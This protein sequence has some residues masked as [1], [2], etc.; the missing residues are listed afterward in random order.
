MR[1]V[2]KDEFKRIYFAHLGRGYTEEYWQNLFE[3][4]RDHENFVWEHFVSEPTSPQETEMIIV[5]DYG[6]HQYRL[7]FST[8]EQ[9]E[10]WYN[11][12]KD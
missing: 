10:S 7:F 8:E 12:G 1:K 4:K 9:Q 11:Q 2:S 5:T 6:T 3:N